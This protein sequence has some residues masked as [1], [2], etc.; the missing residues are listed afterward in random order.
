ML[1]VELINTPH[2][3]LVANSPSVLTETNPS[4][5]AKLPDFQQGQR[6]PL[7]RVTSTTSTAATGTM[8]AAPTMT[9]KVSSVADQTMVANLVTNTG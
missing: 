3:F 1:L 9:P 7:P 6:S 5:I 8:R 4:A 2:L